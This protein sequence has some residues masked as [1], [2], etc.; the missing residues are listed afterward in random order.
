MNAEIFV[1]SN[2]TSDEQK[3]FSLSSAIREYFMEK[4]SG[5]GDF[6]NG[7]QLVL[8]CD[9]LTGENLF[10]AG[11]IFCDLGKVTEK[12]INVR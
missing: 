9:F 12:K 10:F 8:W 4:T 6:N 3:S 11:I 5:G 2:A 7:N 1:H